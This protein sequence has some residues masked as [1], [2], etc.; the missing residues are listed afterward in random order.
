[1]TTQTVE[2]TSTSLPPNAPE[3]RF[4][5]TGSLDRRSACRF[6][7]SLQSVERR[8][9]SR[10]TIDLQRCSFLDVVGACILLDAARRARAQ[11]RR[12]AVFGPPPMVRRMLQLTAVDRVVDIEPAYE[13]AEIEPAFAA[14]A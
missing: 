6:V 12:I 5:V 2:S 8:D 3:L 10:L 11:G 9:P 14:A 4:K 13:A 1:M 7:R